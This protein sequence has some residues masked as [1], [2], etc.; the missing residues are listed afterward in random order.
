MSSTRKFGVDGPLV[1]AAIA[2]AFLHLPKTLHCQSLASSAGVRL[3]QHLSPFHPLLILG[4]HILAER[5]ITKKGDFN[6]HLKNWLKPTLIV[7]V[8][9]ICGCDGIPLGFL[10]GGTRFGND[11]GTAGL[12]IPTNVMEQGTRLPSNTTFI[13]TTVINT[14]PSSAFQPGR[15]GSFF[16]PSGFAVDTSTG[17]FNGVRS[18]AVFTTISTSGSNFRGSNAFSFLPLTV[19]S[20]VGNPF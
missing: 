5:L 15:S 16:T 11:F 14:G 9:C 4:P 12:T 7:M 3:R 2:R 18:G 13:N 8:C 17:G 1:C 6:M 20:A 19:P 10:F